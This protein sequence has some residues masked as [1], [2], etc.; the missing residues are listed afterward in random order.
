M[1]NFKKLFIALPLVLVMLFMAVPVAA[2]VNTYDV[3]VGAQTLNLK[4]DKGAATEI[5]KNNSR[6]VPVWGAVKS[7]FDE[8]GRQTNASQGAGWIKLIQATPMTWVEANSDIIGDFALGQ[9]VVANDAAFADY[10]LPSYQINHVEK[11][12]TD[13]VVPE[14][15]LE[16]YEAKTVSHYIANENKLELVEDGKT[17]TFA[18]LNGY[19]FEV[20]VAADGKTATLT[21]GKQVAKAT[22]NDESNWT[23]EGTIYKY[24]KGDDITA[25]V[26]ASSVI[27]NVSTGITTAEVTGVGPVKVTIKKTPAAIGYAEA[28]LHGLLVIVEEKYVPVT[29]KHHYVIED[30]EELVQEAKGQQEKGVELTTANIKAEWLKE[31]G[32]FKYDPAKTR[33][34][35][36]ETPAKDLLTVGEQ[37]VTGYVV[38]LFYTAGEGAD[39]DEIDAAFA[40]TTTAV[41]NANVANLPATGAASNFAL[42]LSSAALV[43]VGLFLKK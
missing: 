11:V 38:D 8:A 10:A 25:D 17:Y 3:H 34:E 19:G 16:D 40:G 12:V 24:F 21:Y 2:E 14:T 26:V 22:I 30:G 42:V 27:T 1:K 5:F 7:Y 39:T 31:V 13:I 23:M 43:V 20:K 37:F 41:A 9:W 32:E 33:V 29:I 6:M 36:K 35:V 4:L 15:M 28:E 18:E